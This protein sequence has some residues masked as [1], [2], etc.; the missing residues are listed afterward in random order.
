MQSTR[1]LVMSRSRTASE[2][3]FSIPSTARPTRV[4]SAPS[5]AGS[6]G[7]STNSSSQETGTFTARVSPGE[8]LQHAQVVGVEEADVVDAVAHH[9]HTVDAQAER[10]PRHLLRV[11]GDPPQTLVH[12]LEHGGGHHS[13]AHDL[14]PARPLADAA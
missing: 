12:R 1:L 2:P 8:L 10:K 13:R 14:Q 11:V 6:T 3:S 5:R 7:T 9:G 4:K